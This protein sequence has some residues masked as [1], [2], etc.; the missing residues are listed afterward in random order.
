MFSANGFVL[1][2][3]RRRTTK[4]EADLDVVL[5]GEGKHKVFLTGQSFLINDSVYR[6]DVYS[7][8]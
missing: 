3:E 4:R 1:A 8:F 6:W 2:Q 7:A 5:G